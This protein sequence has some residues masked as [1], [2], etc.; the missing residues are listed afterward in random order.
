M[1]EF[2]PFVWTK[3]LNLDWQTYLQHHQP[4]RVHHNDCF[5]NALK[6]MGTL[7]EEQTVELARLFPCGVSEEAVLNTMKHLYPQHRTWHFRNILQGV[8]REER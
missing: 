2:Q 6:F 4:E 5:P 3:P 7:N 8:F 1:S